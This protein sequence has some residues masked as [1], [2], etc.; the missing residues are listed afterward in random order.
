MEFISVVAVLLLLIVAGAD[1][2]ATRLVLQDP[3][4]APRRR[5]VQLLAVWLIPVAG[6]LFV[7][8]S[9]DRDERDDSLGLLRIGRA[10]DE[11]IEN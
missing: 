7:F 11:A 5:R 1:I 8:A 3:Q 4:L 9:A 6:A 2:L 10:I